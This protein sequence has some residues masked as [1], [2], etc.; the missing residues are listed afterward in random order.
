[1]KGCMTTGIFPPMRKTEA[2]TAAEI[3][4]SAM[5]EEDGM[6]VREDILKQQKEVGKAEEGVEAVREEADG[7]EMKMTI[8]CVG[9]GEDVTKIPEGI[10]REKEVGRA[11]VVVA[12]MMTM[13]ITM[14]IIT[15]QDGA[16]VLVAPAV[17]GLAI[18][19]AI[20]K[21]QKG[22]G[23]EAKGREEIMTSM[24]ITTAMKAINI[25][26]N[27]KTKTKTKMV[28]EGADAGPEIP[29]D[30]LAGHQADKDLQ[31]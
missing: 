29:A 6:V 12:V 22:D 7:R 31:A 5:K 11:V 2:A 10:L 4:M 24:K 23:A 8:T 21:H 28:V 3:T 14:M 26:T 19:R 1:M 15:I 30:P 16:I 18:L 13:M 25:Q 9:K 20:P 27:M 17:D